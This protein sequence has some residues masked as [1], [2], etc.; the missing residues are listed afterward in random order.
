[1]TKMMRIGIFCA[2]CLI[3]I[4]C[5]RAAKAIAKEQLP[6][7]QTLSYFHDILRL[8]YTENTGAALGLGDSLSR[9]QSFW[10]LSMLPLCV[11]A[12]LF[13]Y[14]VRR[15]ATMAWPR[16][17][18][19]ALILAGGLGNIADRL[20]NDRHVTDF[21]NIGIGP[22]RTAIFN[23]ADLYITVGVLLLVAGYKKTGPGTGSEAI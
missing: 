8:E 22:L 23:F 2:A 4:G 12:I 14:V 13:V 10:L 16:L 17:L 19:L 15:S 7:D 1:M 6:G 3:F 18:A 9:G 21:L 5:D 11:L 20:L